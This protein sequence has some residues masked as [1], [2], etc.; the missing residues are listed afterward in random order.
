LDRNEIERMLRDTKDARRVLENSRHAR[1]AFDRLDSNTL[2]AFNVQQNY[3]VNSVVE[4]IIK[5]QRLRSHDHD[6]AISEYFKN[7]TLIGEMSINQSRLLENQLRINDLSIQR[8]LGV[9][10]MTYYRI[11]VGPTQRSRP[12]FEPTMI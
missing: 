9:P 7:R 10:Y 5:R 1:E 3:G 6:H 11:S 4:E 2:R 8:P 12:R